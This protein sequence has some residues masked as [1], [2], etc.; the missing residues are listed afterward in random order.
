MKILLAIILGFSLYAK[1]ILYICDDGA[2][3][4]PF[5]FYKRVNGK[6]DKSKVVGALVDM[7]NVMFKDLNITYKLDL[8]P[9]K[10][11]TYLV[12]VYDRAKKYAIFPGLYSKERAKILYI[13]KP[14]YTTHQVIWFSKKRFTK[15]EILNKVKNDINSLRICDVNG[16]NT[17][18]YYT[19]FNL[20]KNK[21]INQEATSQCA[22]LKKISA[23][24]CDIMVA[25]K[26][27]ILGY[28]MIG[29]CKIPEDISYVPYDKLKTSKFRLFISKK[30]PKAKELL[31]KINK[32]IEKMDKSGIREKI[33]KKWIKE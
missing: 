14:I 26:E 3:W 13:T 20:D 21:T 24:R 7:Y 22:V 31:Q 17:S 5:V 8:L 33:L 11:C 4:P 15:D 28:Q 1:D 19:V 2:E 32:E 30:Y 12:S 18:F 16:Y 23:N 10:R 29:K 9:W 27:A 6:V 25:S